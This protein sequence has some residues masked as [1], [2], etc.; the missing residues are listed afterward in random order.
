MVLL[1]RIAVFFVFSVS[2]VSVFGQTPGIVKKDLLFQSDILK[3][4]VA[5]N[6]YLPVNYS[7]TKTYPVIFY[8]HW[9]GGNQNSS[10]DFINK[11]DSLISEKKFQE[12]I[13]IAPDAKNTWYLD[14][15][16][17]KYKYSAMFINEFIPF[18]R[19]QLSIAQ[20]PEKNIVIGASMGGFG[21]LRFS[22]LR[23]DLFGVCVSFMAGISTKEQIIQDNNE[24][25][26]KYH[27]NLYGQNLKGKARVSH[28]FVAVNPLYIAAK[29][30]SE[31]LKKVKWYIQSCDDDYHSLGNAELHSVFHRKQIKHEFRVIDGSHDGE[32]VNQSMD[33]ALNFIKNS[34]T[35]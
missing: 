14:D 22:M 30:K 35:N 13:I 8:L 9:F 23:P 28:H 26:V 34:I 5:Y 24:D 16:A 1:K 3:E 10:N 20:T 7:K 11:I 2:V 25:Y 31:D 21:A 18:V 6:L 27:Q 32:C 33:E 12:I 17:G 4:R 19:K 29:S 15:F